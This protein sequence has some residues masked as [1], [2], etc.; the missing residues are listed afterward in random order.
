MDEPGQ[1]GP[2]MSTHEGHDPAKIYIYFLNICN[3]LYY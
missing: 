1:E 2:P 3:I